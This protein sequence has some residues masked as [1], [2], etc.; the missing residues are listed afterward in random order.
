[1]YAVH[2]TWHLGTAEV[3]E[4]YCIYLLCN[5]ITRS[6]V[7][8]GLCI[9]CTQWRGEHLNKERH[10]PLFFIYFLNIILPLGVNYKTNVKQYYD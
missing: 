10:C 9:T 7:L 4:C 1:M 5:L 8:N 2:V 3:G 6:D